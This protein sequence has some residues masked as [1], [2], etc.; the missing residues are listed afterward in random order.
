MGGVFGEHQTK[1]CLEISDGTSWSMFLFKLNIEF[2]GRTVLHMDTSLSSLSLLITYLPRVTVYA[3]ARYNQ[4]HPNFE[5]P[6]R[7]ESLDY[8]SMV[9]ARGLLA[10]YFASSRPLLLVQ[11]LLLM[12]PH[13]PKDDGSP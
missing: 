2:Q 12:L 1:V 4:N 13:P 3:N 8:Q 10:R 9:H 5:I 11:K 6:K 7:N